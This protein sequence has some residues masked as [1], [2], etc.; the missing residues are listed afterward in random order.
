MLEKFKIQMVTN[1]HHIFGGVDSIIIPDIDII[2]PNATDDYIIVD[3]D[4][5]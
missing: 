5:L 2:K 4:V 3:I 1:S